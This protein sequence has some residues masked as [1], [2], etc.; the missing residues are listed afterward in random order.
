MVMV[1]VLLLLLLLLLLLVVVVVVVVVVLLLPPLLLPSL[2]A[3]IHNKLTITLSP[4]H[5]AGVP[6]LP[7]IP[8]AQYYYNDAPCVWQIYPRWRR[9]LPHLQLGRS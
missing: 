9:R 8:D 4:P 6:L 5:T 2:N 3:P 1:V 7:L